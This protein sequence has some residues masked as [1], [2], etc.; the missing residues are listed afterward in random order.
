MMTLQLLASIRSIRPAMNYDGVCAR[1]EGE[2]DMTAISDDVA[3]A[4][5]ADALHSGRW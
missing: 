3:P 5:Y 2:G 1:V 4:K